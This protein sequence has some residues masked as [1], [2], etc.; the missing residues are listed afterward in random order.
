LT[1]LQF[2]LLFE[3]VLKLLDAERRAG[4]GD[5][6]L[7]IH[8]LAQVIVTTHPKPRTLSSVSVF[9]VRKSTVCLKSA[10]QL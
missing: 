3:F 2:E 4:P 8:R 7:L 1:S 5:Q 10:G 9:A 6:F